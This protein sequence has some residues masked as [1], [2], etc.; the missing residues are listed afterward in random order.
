MSFQKVALVL[1]NGSDTMKAGFAKEEAPDVMFPTVIGQTAVAKQMEILDRPAPFIGKEAKT[2]RDSL[3]LTHPITNS[4]ITDFE[5]MEEIWRFTF[6]NELKANPEEHAVLLTEAPFNPK[7]NREKTT[8]IMFETFHTPAMFLAVAP[9]LALYASGRKNGTII[10]CGY[11]GSHA[12]P[13]YDGF[14]ITKSICR[15]DIAGERLTDYLK[16]CLVERDNSVASVEGD[17]VRDIKEKLCYV[18]L[19]FEQEISNAESNSSLQKTYELPDGRVITIG[20]ER[21]RCPEAMF[22]PSFLGVES[23]GIH[24]TT[25]N[26]IMKCDEDTRKELCANIVLTGGS[27]MFQGITERIQKEITS[28]APAEKVK[29]IAPPIDRKLSA[30]IGGSILASL[31]TFQSLWITKGE[32][33]EAGPAIVERK[34]V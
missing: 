7:V 27:T 22:Q 17:L 6:S 20:N 23:A 28:L 30:W 5:G 2:R 21:F 3:E 33:E 9:V 26:S 8:Q 15:L 13:I 10:E 1:D 24:E 25:Y 32:Y 31:D 4:I 34:C 11:G 29:I 18:A 19:D 12:V 14:A 16:T